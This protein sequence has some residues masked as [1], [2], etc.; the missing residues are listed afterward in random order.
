MKG[1]KAWILLIFFLIGMAMVIEDVKPT[2]RFSKNTKDD[3]IQVI[4]LSNYQ[5]TRQMVKLV[6][7]Q[8]DQELDEEGKIRYLSEHSYQWRVMENAFNT[9]IKDLNTC[10]E[11]HE[12]NSPLYKDIETAQKL[13]IYAVQNRD[14]Q[15]LI[16]AHNILHDLEHYFFYHDKDKLYHGT[17]KTLTGKI[18]HKTKLE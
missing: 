2:A 11:L 14:V 6:H 7:A 18:K 9:S 12:A 5:K 10:L 3:V 17:T 15:A 4:G 16:D 13:L 1:L 8:L